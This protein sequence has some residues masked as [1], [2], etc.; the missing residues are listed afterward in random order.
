MKLV[1]LA[2]YQVPSV[3][4]METQTPNPAEHGSFCPCPRTC[5]QLL[6]RASEGHAVSPTRAWICILQLPNSIGYRTIFPLVRIGGA[7]SSSPMSIQDVPAIQSFCNP[8]SS[9]LLSHFFRSALFSRL[10]DLQYAAPRALRPT[11]RD[12]RL[13]RLPH[14]P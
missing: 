5:H 11:S 13:R 9:T 2:T 3:G 8:L 7:A 1:L 14:Q 10:R 12:P 6:H 4:Y